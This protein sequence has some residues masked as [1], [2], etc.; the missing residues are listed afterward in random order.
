MT[1]RE[2]MLYRSNT[3]ALMAVVMMVGTPCRTRDYD[4]LVRRCLS[5][6]GSIYVL[7]TVRFRSIPREEE[8]REKGRMAIA[9]EELS[10]IGPYLEKRRRKGLNILIV[11][12]S[13]NLVA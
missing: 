4:R 6:V 7:L 10:A 11:N 12:Q 9:C 2:K 13:R 1:H 3:E 8:G 5:E